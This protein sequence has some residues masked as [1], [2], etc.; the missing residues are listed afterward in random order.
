[1]ISNIFNKN[2]G[3]NNFF[4]NLIFPIV[5][6]II[7]FFSFFAYIYGSTSLNAVILVTSCFN[8]VN[9]FI[10]LL[11]QCASILFINTYFSILP[12][13]IQLSFKF[14]FLTKIILF[15]I[16]RLF[17][18][19]FFFKKILEKYSIKKILNI[20]ILLGVL[21]V[22]LSF[23]YFIIVTLFNNIS[24][25]IKILPIGQKIEFY[26]RSL[27]YLLEKF[28]NI[29]ISNITDLT[30]YISIGVN[31]MMLNIILFMNSYF[32]SFLLSIIVK[33]PTNEIFQK[34]DRSMVSASKFYKLL[35]LGI[36]SLS[37][38]LFFLKYSFLGLIIFSIF[39]SFFFLFFLIGRNLLFNGL[40]EK[41]GNNFMLTIII[42][43]LLMQFIPL[44]PIILIILG[45]VISIFNI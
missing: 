43:I 24:P 31:S 15:D 20:F 34:F 8:P 30:K 9:P 35:C 6:F 37:V 36:F 28:N 13:F 17:I 19:S 4:K 25:I 27:P 3:N 1:M 42:F 29:N 21:N 10:V 39:L 18:Y 26:I 12:T 44:F 16:L 7:G 33:D 45:F 32:A 41:T 38:I 40:L 2:P 14:D 23:F 11:G 5:V 22:L